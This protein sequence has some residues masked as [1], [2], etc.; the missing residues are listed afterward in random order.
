MIRYHPSIKN[1]TDDNHINDD[2]TRNLNNN[3][4]TLHNVYVNNTKKSTPKAYTSY[5]Y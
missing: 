2:K 3:Q 5:N 4:E 1:T